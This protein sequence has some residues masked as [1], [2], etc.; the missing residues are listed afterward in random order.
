MFG[1]VVVECFDVVEEFMV[2][3]Y[4]CFYL[5]VGVVLEYFGVGVVF[6]VVCVDFVCGDVDYEFV[7]VGI[8]FCDLF[9]V[10]VFGVVVDDCGY[11]WLG[12]G[13]C[14]ELFFF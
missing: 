3:N 12:F 14:Y 10:I 6:V 2:G 9:D 11:V 7:C 13:C 5:W 4:W 1:C 8:W